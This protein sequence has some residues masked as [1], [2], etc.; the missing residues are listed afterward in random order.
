MYFYFWYG[1]NEHEKYGESPVKIN[2]D[3]KEF[4][5]LKVTCNVPCSTLYT[6]D[7][8]KPKLVVEGTASDYKLKDGVI[9]L[10]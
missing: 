7:G 6:S 10:Y 5:V 9:Y 1:K 2:I 3:G 8:D 4:C